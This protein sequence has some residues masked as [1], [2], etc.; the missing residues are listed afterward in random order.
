MESTH[1]GQLR[2][3]DL[4]KELSKYPADAFIWHEGCD[5]WGAAKS[6]EWDVSDNTI[7]ITRF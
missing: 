2:V 3:C 6:V 1:E 5:C 7:L 4:I